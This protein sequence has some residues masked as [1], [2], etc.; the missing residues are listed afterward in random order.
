MDFNSE[1][2]QEVSKAITLYERVQSITVTKSDEYSE[3]ASF[4]K[5]VK[6]R[7]KK[8]EETEEGM[9]KPFRDGYN[10]ARQAILDFFS[11]PKTKLEKAK[12]VLSQ[13]MLA[14]AEEQKQREREEQ[15]RLQELA[16]KRSEEEALR[17]ALEAEAAGEKEEAEQIISEPVYVPPIKVMSVIPRSKESH[18]RETW[19]CEGFDLMTT[20]KAIAEGK[21]PLQSVQYDMPFLNKQAISYKQSLNIPGTRA[22]SKKTQI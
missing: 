20:V 15:L 12:T 22:I 19:S 18:I 8:I 16:R 11:P 2:Q 14:W 1:A 10:N 5:E 21:A 9:I 7:L 3:A 13:A 17:L 4:L 6:S